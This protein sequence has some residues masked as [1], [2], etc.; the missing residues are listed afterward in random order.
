MR[1]LPLN[2]PGVIAET[3]LRV[4][5]SQPELVEPNL[6]DMHRL[7]RGALAE[8]RT[9]LL[10]LRPRMLEKTPLVDLLPYLANALMGRKQITVTLDL[11]PDIRLPMPVKTACYR[12]AQ[13]ALNNIGKYAQANQ[14][15]LRLTR[16]GRQIILSLQDNG[17][18][19][20]IA[21]VPPGHLGLGIMQE[22]AE[23]IGA[24]LA[25]ESQPGRG[26]EVRLV[27]TAPEE[28]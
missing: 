23:A 21:A 8:M 14:V 20:D 4:W 12:I 26:T 25:I 3:L 2:Q 19:F 13:E 7:T 28:G 15:W 24:S 18:G 27:W 11:E 5:R 10:E 9:L 16:Q 1:Q 17:V 22:R 6:K